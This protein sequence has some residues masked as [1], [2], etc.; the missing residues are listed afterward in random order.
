MPRKQLSLTERRQQV[1]EFNQRYPVGTPVIVK[2]A[3]GGTLSTKTTAKAEIIGGHTPVVW[4]EDGFSGAVPLR[5][6]SPM[7]PPAAQTVR[8]FRDAE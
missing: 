6:V 2:L 3:E 7:K 5:D 4:I 1:K 8:E